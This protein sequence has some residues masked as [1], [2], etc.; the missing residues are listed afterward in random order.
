M[1][2]KGL[3]QFTLYLNASSQATVLSGHR[4]KKPSNELNVLIQFIWLNNFWLSSYVLCESLNVDCQIVHSGRK[5]LFAY[6]GLMIVWQFNYTAGEFWRENGVWRQVC[7]STLKFTA[8][9]W[10][11]SHSILPTEQIPHSTQSKKLG[12]W[13]Q[14]GGLL[15]FRLKL[16]WLKL[17]FIPDTRVQTSLHLSCQLQFLLKANCFYLL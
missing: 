6:N 8:L 1:E 7:L 13:V 12:G 3:R 11:W 16:N 2:K 17:Y 14:K 9:S 5:K 10:I 4:K 15:K